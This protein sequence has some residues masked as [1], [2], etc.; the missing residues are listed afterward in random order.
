MERKDSK[1]PARNAGSKKPNGSAA[2]SSMVTAQPKAAKIDA[3][4]QAITPL[5]STIKVRG[6]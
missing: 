5:P 1:N 2:L 6:R 3:Y 4:S